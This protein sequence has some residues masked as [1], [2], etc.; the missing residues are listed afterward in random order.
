MNN[1]LRMAVT[2]PAE[3]VCMLRDSKQYVVRTSTVSLDQ[4]VW[5]PLIADDSLGEFSDTSVQTSSSVQK[6]QDFTGSPWTVQ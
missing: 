5:G 6:N 3:T 1:L 2:Y 4:S